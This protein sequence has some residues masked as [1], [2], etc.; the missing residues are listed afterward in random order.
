MSVFEGRYKLVWMC[1]VMADLC[2]SARK[3]ASEVSGRL[4]EA[5]VT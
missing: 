5:H 3:C 4:G 2:S 1:M